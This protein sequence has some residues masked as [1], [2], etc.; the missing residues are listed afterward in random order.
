MLV[1]L[2]LAGNG[3]IGIM[4]FVLQIDCLVVV[5]LVLVLV[6]VVLT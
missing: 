2:W 5:D 6:L 3:V 4:D 1:L